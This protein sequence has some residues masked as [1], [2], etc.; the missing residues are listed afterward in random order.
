VED[1]VIVDGRATT[2][3]GDGVIGDAID[4]FTPSGADPT[5]DA[6]NMTIALNPFMERTLTVADPLSP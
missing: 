3:F 5:H 2:P 6:D 1:A 4:R